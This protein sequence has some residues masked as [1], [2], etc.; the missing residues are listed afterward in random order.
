M[1]LS[2]SNRLTL[3]TESEST[4]LGVIVEP[5]DTQGTSTADDFE[6]CYDGHALRCKTWRLLGFSPSPLFKFVK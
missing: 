1:Y 2:D 5:L 4:K 6:P 3:I